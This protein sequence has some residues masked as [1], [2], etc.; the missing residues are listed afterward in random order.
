MHSIN[1]GE[2]LMD[3]YNKRMDNKLVS[4]YVITYP[5]AENQKELNMEVLN[6]NFRV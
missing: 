5:Q 2:V 3:D 1:T 4:K 6:K